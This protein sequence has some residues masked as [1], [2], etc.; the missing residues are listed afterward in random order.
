MP[1]ANITNNTAPIYEASLTYESH[2]KCGTTEVLGAGED[3]NPALNGSNAWKIVFLKQ[4]VLNAFT[5][6]NISGDDGD[7]LATTFDAG[8]EIMANITGFSITSG[9]VIVYKD[10]PNS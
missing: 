9:L 4:T 8:I 3:F 6:G 7:K 2:G 5:A 10:C 1:E